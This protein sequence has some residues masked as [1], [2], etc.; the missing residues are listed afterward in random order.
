MVLSQL[1]FLRKHQTYTT[2][3]TEQVMRQ[4]GVGFHHHPIPDGLICFVMGFTLHDVRTDLLAVFEELSVGS[5]ELQPITV[6]FQ[7]DLILTYTQPH[8]DRHR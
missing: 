7:E 4:C 5:M 6:D 3:L 1:R 8:I 2:V